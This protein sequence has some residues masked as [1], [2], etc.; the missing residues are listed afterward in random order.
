[1]EDSVQQLLE[2]YPLSGAAST[3]F[4]FLPPS[5]LGQAGATGA[6]HPLLGVPVLRT[7]ADLLAQQYLS[8]LAAAAVGAPATPVSSSVNVNE[9]AINRSASLFFL[10]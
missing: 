7:P 6:L 1:M 8:A 10:Y 4:P 5:L 9:H 2:R 3:I